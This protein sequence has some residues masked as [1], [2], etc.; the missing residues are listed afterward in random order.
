MMEPTSLIA[1]LEQFLA[2]IKNS[3]TGFAQPWRLFQFAILVLGFL[4]AHLANRRLEPRM[5]AWMRG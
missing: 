2:P 5:D 3:L 1:D 4:I